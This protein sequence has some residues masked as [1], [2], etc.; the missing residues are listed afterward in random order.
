MPILSYY[1]VYR[2]VIIICRN[3]VF[4]TPCG[5]TP[6]RLRR[7]IS[8]GDLASPSQSPALRLR[9]SPKEEEE[10]EKE[11]ETVAV[12]ESLRARISELELQLEDA[13]EKL[14]EKEDTKVVQCAREEE[15]KLRLEQLEAEMETLRT[16]LKLREE[17]RE[18]SEKLAEQ[19][20]TLKVRERL[21]YA[22]RGMMTFY[23]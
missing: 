20:D 21:K 4:K 6:R 9:K 1:E 22:L 18:E 23:K 15:M 17:E 19:L 8:Q 10:K 3:E 13:T 16:E 11:E 2:T 14:M 5:T 12:V 7:S